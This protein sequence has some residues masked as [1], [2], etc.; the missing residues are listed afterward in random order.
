LWREV[1][2]LADAPIGLVLAIYGFLALTELPTGGL[3]P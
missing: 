2:A 3:A 1:A